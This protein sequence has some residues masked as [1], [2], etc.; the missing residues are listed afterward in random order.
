MQ[1]DLVYERRG[2][3]EPLVLLH[4][5]GHHWRAWEP[6]LDK[7]ATV[8]DV[9]AVD[10]PGFGR[11]PMPETGLPHDMTR[12]VGAIASFFAALDLDRPHVA[13][14]SLGGAIALELAA[15][16]QA[17]SATALSPAGFCT[18]AQ[19]RRAVT[20]LRLHRYAAHL[21]EP[22]MRRMLRVGPLRA[23]SF[24]M[25]L[26]R[27]GRISPEAALA[28][29]LA[30]RNARAFETVARNGLRYAFQ[31]APTVPVTVAWGT[32]DRI[33]PYRQAALARQL[34][35]AARHVDLAGCGHVPM[36]D[37]PDLVASVILATTGATV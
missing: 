3:G 25:L 7:L 1:L 15:T 6:V 37:D 36:H 34:L 18:P 32:R 22:V 10:L 19:L 26:A 11:S 17:A 2:A 29:S 14:N 20:V 35:P 21:P 4:G 24:G 33:L 28:D 5:I 8:H 9:I 31:G 12:L 23:V 30:L 13:G 16:G 27:P